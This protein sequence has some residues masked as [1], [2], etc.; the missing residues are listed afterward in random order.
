MNLTSQIHEYASALY[1]IALENDKKFVDDVQD[2]FLA[3]KNNNEIISILSSLNLSKNERKKIVGKI[4]NNEINKLIINF[5]YLL[6]DN[7]FF[8]NI[9][10]IIIDFF[11]IFDEEKQILHVKI[12]TPFALDENQLSKILELI[13][14]KT[15]KELVY[16]IIIDPALIGGIKITYNNNVLDFSIKGKINSLKDK[17]HNINE[18]GER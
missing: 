2:V 11:K 5:M 7:E 15:K 18:G 12:Y 9:I 10:L 17:L 14:I 4:F 8:E 3:F 1:S 13:K 16:D 6:I